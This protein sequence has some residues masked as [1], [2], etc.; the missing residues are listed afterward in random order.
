MPTRYD[1]AKRLY[2]ARSGA[3]S[4]GTGN[5]VASSGGLNGN[6]SSSL[7][8]R[9]GTAVSDS[10]DG[11]VDVKLDTTNIVSGESTTVH[12]ACDSPIS[13]GQRVCVLFS[14][15]GN[16]KAIP[17]GDN[18][19]NGSVKSVVTQYAG[20][21]SGTVAPTNGWSESWPSGS[22]YVWSRTVTT[23]GDGT[24]VISAAVCI[25]RPPEGYD[26]DTTFYATSS[27]SAATTAKVA[28]I[29]SS[30]SGFS[31]KT[32]VVVS[33]RFSSQNTASSPTL[34]VNSTGAKAIYTNGT[35]YAYWAAGTS[36]LFMYDGSYWQCCSAPVYANTVTVGNPASRNMYIDSSHLAVRN[37][38]TEYATFDVDE[39]HLGLNSSTS[40]IFM[41]DDDYIIS[42]RTG[43]GM[44]Q[45]NYL[46]IAPT[47][48]VLQQSVP[49]GSMN[50]VKNEYT[51]LQLEDSVSSGRAALFALDEA[52]VGSSEGAVVLS[53][54]NVDL[55]RSGA[56][57]KP[58]ITVGGAST[59]SL[60]S[61]NSIR[62]ISSVYAEI[63]SNTSSAYASLNIRRSGNYVYVDVPRMTSIADHGY[64]YIEVS[65]M[66]TG[67]AVSSSNFAGAITISRYSGTGT[68]SPSSI[69]TTITTTSSANEFSTIVASPQIVELP[70]PSYSS[71]YSETT[72]RLYFACRSSN[73]TG[74]SNS[75]RMTVKVV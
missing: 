1:I 9:Y 27:T 35:R 52:S 55:R 32:G 61:S 28:T 69:D 23:Y 60:T 19:E 51:G 7:T 21:D 68:P 15:S 47:S 38:T 31:L 56:V 5:S 22:D 29:S 34:N 63:P 14:V 53:A 62:T 65:A 43:Q 3:G 10:A 73:G 75:W 44:S 8:M 58:A 2:G 66:C 16:L 4:S 30:Q 12:C 25:D 37:G 71:S 40:S 26:A 42:N 48:Y 59:Q 57:L 17:I 20:S 18:I 39:I 67:G 33:V 70:K 6:G 49:K 45:G 41:L 54:G 50:F 24:T 46:T 36:V 72:Y 74:T 11:W 13:S 64:A